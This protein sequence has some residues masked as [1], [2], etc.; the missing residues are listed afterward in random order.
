MVSRHSYA[1]LLNS[2]AL[3]SMFFLCRLGYA[4]RSSPLTSTQVTIDVRPAST[5]LVGHSLIL[6]PHS[7]IHTSTAVQNPYS[8][9]NFTNFHTPNHKTLTLYRSKIFDAFDQW[10][11]HV[12]HDIHSHYTYGNKNQQCI[13]RKLIFVS[14]FPS[15]T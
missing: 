8:S 15:T 7:Y 13:T 11:S 12:D 5:A 1:I 2:E 6:A 4:D 14:F 3:L 9:P 10:R